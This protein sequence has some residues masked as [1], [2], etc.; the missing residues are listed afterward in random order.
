MFPYSSYGSD[1]SATN[2]EEYLALSREASKIV[3]RGKRA[4][5]K[6]SRLFSCLYGSRLYGTQTPTS[7][8]DWK[9][10]V[11]P[12]LNDLLLCK[13]IENKVKK[14]NTAKNTRNTADDVDEEFIPLQVFARHFV[15]GQTYALELAFAV[16]GDHAQQTYFNAFNSKEMVYGEDLLFVQFV[17]ELREKFLTSNIKAMMGYVVNQ[18]SLY[19]FKGER[20]NAT[21]ELQ[22]LFV[23]YLTILQRQ[24]IDPLARDTED[25]AE[26]FM[27]ELSALEQ[28]YPK[29]F[30]RDVYDIGGGRM[31]PCLVILEKVLPY[32]NTVAQSQKVL[33]ALT[34]KYGSRAD[35][36]SESNVDWKAT[37][38][39][40]RIVDE[41]LE[42]LSEH[43][44]SFPFHA[45]YVKHLLEM[46]R[47]E[48]PLDPIKKELSAK[49]DK[50]KEME[51][52]TD[53]PACDAEFMQEF[54]TWMVG[55][56]RKFYNQ[57]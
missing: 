50:L 55:W 16:D 43:K 33:K 2:D 53:L 41:G 25:F 47:G 46:K 3:K 56:L 5:S 13:K 11:L 42:L 48:L 44:L 52:F 4:E 57:E 22:G 39:A 6:M 7:D 51:K 15:E 8:L 23:D 14:T 45:D 12:D 34:D 20:L 10:I 24:A 38:H 29:Y 1:L 54:E 49:L 40:M 26:L 32:T 27:Q 21:R 28:K 9:H 36:A 35:A 17:H 18:A 19:S 37:M 30:K 31:K